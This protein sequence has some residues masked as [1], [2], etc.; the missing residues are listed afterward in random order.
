MTLSSVEFEIVRKGI[1]L[2]RDT[3]MADGATLGFTGD[4]N[5]APNSG[6]Q[7]VIYFCPA[8]TAYQNKGVTPF[9]LWDKAGDGPGGVWVQRGNTTQVVYQDNAAIHSDVPNELYNM[10]EKTS[11]E[12]DDLFVVESAAN[13]F[14]KRKVKYS[15][16]GAA[17][18]VSNLIN[19]VEDGTLSFGDLCY[20]S[21][22]DSIWYKASASVENNTTLAAAKGLLGIRISQGR[23]LINGVHTTNSLV[24][25]PYY[26][27]VASGT[28]STTA[29][30][31]NGE[32][33]RAIGYAINSTTLVFN[34][35]ANYVEVGAVTS[36][37]EMDGGYA[38]S[39]YI[40][41]EYIDGGT[42]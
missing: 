6:P 30:I 9:T 37:G 22:V 26:V 4:P 32:I 23:F 20:Q 21:T 1:L 12:D 2:H 35:S 5:T 40:P 10:A 38:G 7:S 18:F 16:A 29:P 28:I 39:I 31:V 27:G 15:N 17:N 13:G 36:G 34:P 41:S 33:V 19:Q 24:V 42:A 3:L 11:L 8:G 25:G 14:Q